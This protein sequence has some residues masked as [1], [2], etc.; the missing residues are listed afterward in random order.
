MRLF[1]S[2]LGFSAA[3]SCLT[4][5]GCRGGSEDAV[6]STN[7]PPK[8]SDTRPDFDRSCAGV[9]RRL[10]LLING[11]K[12]IR[13]E[14]TTPT[15]ATQSRKISIHWMQEKPAFRRHDFEQ[16]ATA[17]PSKLISHCDSPQLQSHQAQIRERIEA[18]IE[19][20]V[21][22]YLEVQQRQELYVSFDSLRGLNAWTR[23]RIGDDEY[24]ITAS[25]PTPDGWRGETAL[26]RL[27]PRYFWVELQ[28][29][30]FVSPLW[31]DNEKID[32][33]GAYYIPEAF[34]AEDREFMEDPK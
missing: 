30:P 33:P 7:P 4:F 34:T 1:L 27:R 17:S 11:D 21:R 2:R 3:F 22:A 5:A 9:Q 10:D 6:A 20:F 14:I 16:W 19:P 32:A 15:T 26:S 12:D 31:V 29:N 8:S 18:F 25:Y 13:L 24:K 23:A 28:S